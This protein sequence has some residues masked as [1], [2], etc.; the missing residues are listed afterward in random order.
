M[1]QLAGILRIWKLSYLKILLCLIIN[2]ETK[3]HGC[4]IFVH[5]VIV[6]NFI[7]VCKVTLFANSFCIHNL[8]FMFTKDRFFNST[9]WMVAI[10]THTFRIVSSVFMLTLIYRSSLTHFVKLDVLRVKSLRLCWFLLLSQTKLFEWIISCV[11]LCRVGWNL[12]VKN[13][14]W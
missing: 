9:F 6:L 4:L 14:F 8:I 11:C 1:S 10:F 2:Q 3:V 5:A 12:I 7:V 13:G